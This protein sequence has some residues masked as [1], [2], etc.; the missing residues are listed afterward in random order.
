MTATRTTP[1]RPAPR[2]RNA[3]P[4]RNSPAGS[5]AGRGG[6]PPGGKR[7][8]VL[9]FILSCPYTFPEPPAG[10]ASPMGSRRG[11]QARDGLVAALARHVGLKADLHFE[12]AMFRPL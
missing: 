3:H 2:D 5:A 4:G 6:R 9:F 1:G 11:P 10:R 7:V 12:H 8:L